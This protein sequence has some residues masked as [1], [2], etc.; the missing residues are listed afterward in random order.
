[1]QLFLISKANRR[2]SLRLGP[3]LLAIGAALLLFYAGGLCARHMIRASLKNLYAGAASAW[4]EAIESER[5]L[6]RQA[7]DEAEKIRTRWPCV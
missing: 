7:K 6:P 2:W 1:M 5:Q 3:L 4:N